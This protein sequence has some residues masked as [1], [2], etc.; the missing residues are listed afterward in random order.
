MRLHQRRIEAHPV[1]GRID[2]GA[3]AF[4]NRARFVMQEIDADLL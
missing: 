1:R 2:V 3:G 4:E